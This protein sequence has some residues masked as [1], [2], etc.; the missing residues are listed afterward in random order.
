M[1]QGGRR[2]KPDELSLPTTRGRDG[3]RIRRRRRLLD[4]A[5]GIY[6][7]R[8]F[9]RHQA[10][11]IQ[12]QRACLIRIDTST[13]IACGAHLPR[14]KLRVIDR[15]GPIVL[16]PRREYGCCAEFANVLAS[17]TFIRGEARN[18][19]R[20]MGRGNLPAAQNYGPGCTQVVIGRSSPRKFHHQSGSS[21]RRRCS[22][23]L[24]RVM[25]TAAAMNHNEAN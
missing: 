22:M 13:G 3:W 18:I 9:N 5:A 14:S 19:T 11:R 12:I 1:R 20:I 17:G 25:H 8:Y 2:I 7:Q 15:F 21:D 23:L 6:T 24:R 4:R 10:I 16:R